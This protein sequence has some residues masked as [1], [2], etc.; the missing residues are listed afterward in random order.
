[1]LT[2]MHGVNSFVRV[3]A[4]KADDQLNSHCALVA[5]GRFEAQIRARHRRSWECKATGPCSCK[6]QDAK[7][8]IRFPEKNSAATSK[9]HNMKKRET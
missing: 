8:I 6:G 1:M 4:K 2:G 9:T 5:Q 3:N 7:K